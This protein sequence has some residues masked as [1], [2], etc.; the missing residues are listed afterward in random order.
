M[1]KAP[2]KEADKVVKSLARK[3]VN[4]PPGASPEVI[5]IPGHQREANLVPLADSIDILTV[6]LGFD[7]EVS[8]G[9]NEGYFGTGDC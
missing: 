5:Y 4:L 7:R 1:A 9:I 6:A 8:V 2:S 3:W